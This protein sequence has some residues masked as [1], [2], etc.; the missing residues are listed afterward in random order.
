MAVE[1]HD[2]YCIRC[3]KRG[4]PIA[5]Q[6]NALRAKNHMKKLYCIHCGGYVNHIECR[7]E[8]DVRRFKTRFENGEFVEQAEISFEKSN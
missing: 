4:I 7:N 1:I 5:R 8:D 6:S 2:F 3:G